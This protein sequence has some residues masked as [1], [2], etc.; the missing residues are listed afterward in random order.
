[1]KVKVLEN[2][3]DKHTKKLHKVGDVLE[4][5]KERFDEIQKVKNLVEVIEEPETKKE[6]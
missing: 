1:M 5:K 4:I 3:I 6:K 2:F